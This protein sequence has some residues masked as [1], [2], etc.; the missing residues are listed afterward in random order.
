MLN[1]NY[2]QLKI[3]LDGNWKYIEKLSMNNNETHLILM[4]AGEIIAIYPAEEG[5]GL[6]LY[7]KSDLSFNIIEFYPETAVAAFT[8]INKLF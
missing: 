6:E 2:E 4:N 3:M 7:Y 8:L 5:E 1:K